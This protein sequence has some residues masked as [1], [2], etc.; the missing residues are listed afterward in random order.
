MYFRSQEAFANAGDLAKALKDPPRPS[1]ALM[2]PSSAG[3]CGSPLRSARHKLAALA[4]VIMAN[5]VIA[6]QR[7][8]GIVEA[9]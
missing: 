1:P 4:G 2:R 7:V 6:N 9:E 3:G 8:G 5:Q